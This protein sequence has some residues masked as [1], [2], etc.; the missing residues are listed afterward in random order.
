MRGSAQA[1][2]AIHITQLASEN[3][4]RL[5]TLRQDQVL[6]G[7]TLSLQ[8]LWLSDIKGRQEPLSRARCL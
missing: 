2:I 1:F 4:P 5:D 8:T 7:R 3:R 6:N